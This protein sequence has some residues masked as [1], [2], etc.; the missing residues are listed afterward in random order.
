MIIVDSYR[1]T[2]TNRQ[3]SH[4][5]I[6]VIR[7]AQ[8]RPPEECTCCGQDKGLGN[9]LAMCAKNRKPPA[10]EAVLC[11]IPAVVYPGAPGR[12]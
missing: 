4:F 7:Y 1:K 11:W 5:S 12:E 10:A 2:R 6:I 9:I 3:C 8:L